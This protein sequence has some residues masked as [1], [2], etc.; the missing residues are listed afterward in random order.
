MSM[1]K[2][3][4]D[5]AANLQE[6]KI[7]EGGRTKLIN[8]LKERMLIDRRCAAFL[9]T[10]TGNYVIEELEL[11]T[12][13]PIEAKERYVLP[14]DSRSCE[15]DRD[16]NTI[17]HMNIGKLKWNKLMQSPKLL[18]ENDVLPEEVFKI[19]P[20]VAKFLNVCLKPSLT[21]DSPTELR[22]PKDYIKSYF[23]ELETFTLDDDPFAKSFHKIPTAIQIPKEGDQQYLEEILETN[24][25]FALN[26][27]YSKESTLKPLFTESDF[28]IPLIDNQKCEH[29]G[30]QRNLTTVPKWHL[31]FPKSLN[32]EGTSLEKFILNE[33]LQK[34]VEYRLR[35]IYM[36]D[37]PTFSEPQTPFDLIDVES[38]FPVYKTTLESAPVITLGDLFKDVDE[39]KVVSEE[40]QRIE[41]TITSED[42]TLLTIKEQTPY[43]IENNTTEIEIEAQSDE[44]A[45]DLPERLSPKPATSI[46]VPKVGEATEL[47]YLQNSH[48]RVNQTTTVVENSKTENDTSLEAT[49]MFTTHQD[50]TEQSTTKRSIDEDL[51]DLIA[52]KRHKLS[53]IQSKKNLPPIVDLLLSNSTYAKDHVPIEGVSVLEPVVEKIPKKLSLFKNDNQC[54]NLLV[55]NSSFNST[56][57][58]LN[59]LKQLDRDTSFDIFEVELGEKDVDFILSPTDGLLLID[60]QRSQQTNTA[61][62]LVI[63]DRILYNKLKYKNLHI[64]ITCPSLDNSENLLFMQTCLSILDVEVHLCTNEL[65]NI[66]QWIRKLCE[67]YGFVKYPEENFE[68]TSVCFDFKLSKFLLTSTI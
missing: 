53:S 4:C 36:D 34:G 62:E 5:Y 32:T 17:E 21:L 29:Q 33:E 31:S 16:V 56:K 26:F 57:L 42:E 37:A 10:A 35:A 48:I 13:K 51:E 12:L 28:Q 38:T 27:D 8:I 49:K 39:D 54:E 2:W 55:F 67:V 63:Q 20:E 15:Q 40:V 1:P 61:G 7:F 47:S 30:V 52:K 41:F 11:P 65:E 14:C 60:F 44:E 18:S 64:I 22:C 68:E 25:G 59:I 24:D 3:E 23:I 9:K 50:L 58:N 45:H 46:T 43:L 6:V 66:C 19:T